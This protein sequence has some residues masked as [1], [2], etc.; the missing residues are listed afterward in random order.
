MYKYVYICMYMHTVYIITYLYDIIY[1][2]CLMINN[3][4]LKK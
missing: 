4:H 3:K 1:K 2:K